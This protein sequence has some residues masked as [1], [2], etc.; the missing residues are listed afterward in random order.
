MHCTNFAKLPH[1]MSSVAGLDICD[2]I[3]VLQGR[4]AECRSKF[5]GVR[6]VHNVSAV[7]DVPQSATGKRYSH[8]AASNP[9]DLSSTKPRNKRRSP[10]APAV[11]VAYF[12]KRPTPRRGWWRPCGRG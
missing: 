1:V 2:N 6:P 5:P 12:A 10:Q 11:L 4:D 9:Q 7:F 3:L 8:C